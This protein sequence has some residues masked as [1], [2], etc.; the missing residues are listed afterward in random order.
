MV[1]DKI[2]QDVQHIKKLLEKLLTYLKD[3]D[4]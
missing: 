1:M 3:Y 4:I 2:E